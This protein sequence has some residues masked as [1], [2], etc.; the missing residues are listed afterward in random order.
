VLSGSLGAAS[1]AEHVSLAT[2]DV[3]CPDGVYKPVWPEGRP[4]DLRTWG[5]YCQAGDRATGQATTTPFT[6]PGII[7]L[8]VSGYPSAWHQSLELENLVDGKKLP[9]VVRKI[10][11]SQWLGFEFTLPASWVGKPVRLIAKDDGT[12]P[13]CWLGFSEPVPNSDRF[14]WR[15]AVVLLGRTVTHFVLLMLVFFAAASLVAWK[16]SRETIF[17]GLAGLVAVAAAG[18]VAFWLW[19]LSPR[20]GHLVSFLLPLLAAACLIWIRSKLDVGGRQALRS[21]LVPA[22]LMFAASLLILTSGYLY[23]GTRDALETPGIRFTHPLPA[24][25]ALPFTFAEGIRYQRIPR[26]ISADWLTSDRPPL[27]TGIALSQY[28]FLPQPRELGYEIVGALAQSLWI[29]AMW[30]LLV[31]FDIDRR[32]MSTILAVTILSGFVFVNTFYVWP[33]LLAGAYVIPIAAVILQDK[34]RKRLECSITLSLI[35]GGSIAFAVL[36]HGTSFFALIG[37]ALTAALM[38]KRLPWKPLALIALAG[39]LVYLPWL[40]YQKLYDPPGDRLLK[41]QLAGVAQIDSRPFSRVILTAYQD[42]GLRNFLENKRHNLVAMTMNEGEGVRNAAALVTGSEQRVRAAK[43]LRNIFFFQ[44]LAD[45]GFLAP[46]F[47]ALVIGLSRRHRSTN[48]RLATALSAYVALTLAVWCLLMFMPGSTVI[49]Q[50]SYATVIFAFAACLLALWSV[51]PALATVLGALQ[52]L[53]N[54]LAYFIFRYDPLFE[55]E[56]TPRGLE[57]GELILATLSLGAVFLLLAKN[58]GLIHFRMG[59]RVSIPAAEHAPLQTR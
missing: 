36:S 29:P 2:N 46:G 50:G 4:A 35:A 41:L 9:F 20:A 25:N 58:A 10:P 26:P 11:R 19:F 44:F 27:Q 38:R 40:L 49:H 37:L 52:I 56:L 39:F 32:L 53:L 48:W 55:D 45:L 1:G 6:A 28:P 31:S 23:G 15:N 30:L 21:L 14:R 59:R 57:Y 54:F 16:V 7:S 13:G 51:S 22:A 33:K 12:G 43:N 5:S 34:L 17:A 24:D 42:L 18:Y 3:F 47:A 8:Y